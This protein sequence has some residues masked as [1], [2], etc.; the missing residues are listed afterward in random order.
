METEVIVSL[1]G[2]VTTIVGFARYLLGYW[3]KQQNKLQ[4]TQETLYQ[5]S[6]KSLGDTIDQKGTE[7]RALSGRLREFEDRVNTLIKKSGSAQEKLEAI[8]KEM[9][10]FTADT[11]VR[12][13]AT[14]H[15]VDSLKSVVVSIGNDLLLIKGPKKQ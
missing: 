11:K 5:I 12:C 3:F 9:E 7:I 2:L 15:L 4:E 8:S 10:K 6:V 1:I 13:D 14:E